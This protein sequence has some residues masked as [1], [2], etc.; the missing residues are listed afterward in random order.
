MTAAIV[1]TITNISNSEVLSAQM[2]NGDL[3]VKPI[4]NGSSNVS[5][6]INSNG[7]LAN[8][9]VAII[10]SDITDVHSASQHIVRSAFVANGLLHVNNCN[11]FHFRVYD[12]VGNLLSDFTADNA[13]FSLP[14]TSQHQTTY[15]ISG[16]NGK[17]KVSFKFIVH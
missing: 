9:S 5:I 13:N 2:K 8:V 12:L 7:K 16:T 14:F 4:K 3:V 11:G 10:I 17:E 15:I 6:H 1:K